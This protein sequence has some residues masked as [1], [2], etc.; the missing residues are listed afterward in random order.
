MF[1]NL[2][3]CQLVSFSRTELTYR[4]REEKEECLVPCVC[5]VTGL[6]RVWVSG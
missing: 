5:P 1:L 3:G 4:Q 6:E 2:W